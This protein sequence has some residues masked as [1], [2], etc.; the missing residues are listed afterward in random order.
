MNNNKDKFILESLYEQCSK[1]ILNENIGQLEL[2]TPSVPEEKND[3]YI[4]AENLIKRAL[5]SEQVDS[6]SE[7]FKNGVKAVMAAME[8]SPQ[9]IDEVIEQ[10]VVGLQ[11]GTS[12]DSNDQ[13]E[14]SITNMESNDLLDAY[15]KVV[16]EAKKKKQKENNEYAIC[17]ASVGREDEE[18]YKSC[19]EK[20]KKQ[21]KK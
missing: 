15:N 10:V 1:R 8:H 13:P 9:D 11:Q 21:F 12:F 17:T 18:K 14:I 3:S 16:S 4:T 7:H 20:V 6:S 2:Q 19:K 5:N